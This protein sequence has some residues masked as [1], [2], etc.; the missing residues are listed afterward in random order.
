MLE[1]VT[2]QGESAGAQWVNS[3]TRLSPY[4]SS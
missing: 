4:V 1:N 3:L 2:H